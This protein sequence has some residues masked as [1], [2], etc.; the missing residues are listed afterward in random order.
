MG[1]LGN[2]FDWDFF[3]GIFGFL[4]KIGAPFVLI[5]VAI[6]ATGKLIGAL[7]AAVKSKNGG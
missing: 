2:V 3:W 1:N 5:M 4:L 6:F 7:V